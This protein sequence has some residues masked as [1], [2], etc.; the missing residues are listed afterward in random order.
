MLPTNA[1]VLAALVV[2]SAPVDDMLCMAAPAAD[3]IKLLPGYGAP[4]TDHY[5]GYLDLPATESNKPVHIHYWLTTSMSASPEKDPVVLW[6]NGGPGASSILFGFF[7]ELG[8]YCECA[9]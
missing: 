1:R 8:P 2:L 6:M 5:S 9:R 7:G 4:K 3:K